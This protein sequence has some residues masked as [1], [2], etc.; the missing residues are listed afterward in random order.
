MHLLTCSCLLRAVTVRSSPCSWPLV[1]DK[2][3]CA[4]CVF[5]CVSRICSSSFA[6]ASFSTYTQ[7]WSAWCQ[8]VL[9]KHSTARVEEPQQQAEV[10]GCLRETLRNM[11]SHGPQKALVPRA[12]CAKGCGACAEKGEI[13]QS[14]AL[15]QLQVLAHVVQGLQRNSHLQIHLSRDEFAAR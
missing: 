10:L 1:A 6:L 2:S 11:P 5:C 3:M 8:R 15:G 14:T 4:A 7:A 13:M 12:C 9:C